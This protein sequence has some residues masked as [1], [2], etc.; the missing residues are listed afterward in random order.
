MKEINIDLLYKNKYR[1][2]MTLR[3]RVTVLVGASASGKTT[4]VRLATEHRL[5][6]KD[7]TVSVFNYDSIAPF[8][9]Q[10]AGIENARALILD[11][12]SV[13]GLLSNNKL[14]DLLKTDKV[15]LL[16][17]RSVPR[18]IQCAYTDIFELQTNG[19]GV[20]AVPRYRDFSELPDADLYSCEIALLDTGTLVTF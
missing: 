11:E 3:S 20:T 8:E 18:E 4:L 16:V 14:F 7:A 9:S 17:T 10:L 6:T 2:Q 19:D 13:I 12:D 1:F 5:K 15:L